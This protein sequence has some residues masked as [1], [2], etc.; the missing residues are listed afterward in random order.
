MENK[1]I[2][3]VTGIF[4][5]ADDIIKASKAIV[6]A[7][8]KKF[9]IHTPYPV[10]GLEQAMKLQRSPLGYFA[11]VLGFGGAALALLFMY[12]TN[13]VAY[14]N[15]IGGKPFFA[16]PALIP[17]TFEITVLMAS[18]GTVLAMIL[19]FFKF[20][21]LSHPLHDTEY[22]KKVSSDKLGVCIE[23]ND[24]LFDIEKVTIF[25]KGIGAKDIQ[26]IYW[27]N[28]EINTKLTLL[29]P[30]FLIGLAFIAIITS[31]AA[32]YLLNKALFMEPFNY[33]MKQQKL[34]AQAVPTFFKDGFS[35]REPVSGTVERGNKPYMYAD[36][37]QLAEKYMINPLT[38]TKENLN[39][40]QRKFHIYCS[41]CHDYQGTGISRLNGQFPNPPTLHSDRVKNWPDGHIYHVITVGQNIMP[42]YAKQINETERWQI[43][44]YVR[45]LQRALN[46]KEGDLK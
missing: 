45:A 46:A 25:L 2:H 32:Y 43:V 5:T 15:N 39:I 8:Y 42:S 1:I 37:V 44:L 7:G 29:N 4:E 9:D 31:S 36:S 33:M 3:S 13:S 23:Y 26:E 24:P 28:E 12:W 27:D 34:S 18:V 16:L 6:A 19:I 10:H 21:N 22:M 38:Y 17:V 20:P 41:P 14:P 35:V 30:K 40:G 11:F